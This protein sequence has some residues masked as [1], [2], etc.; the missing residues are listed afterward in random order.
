VY[1]VSCSVIARIPS[2]RVARDTSVLSLSLS[3]CIALYQ[4]SPSP[5]SPSLSN[6]SMFLLFLLSFPFSLLLP[7][8]STLSLSSRSPLFICHHLSLSLSPPPPI[9]LPPPLSHTICRSPATMAYQSSIHSI[10]R[11]SHH[12]APIMSGGWRMCVP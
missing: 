10:S 1:A 4:P 6:L 5:L 3:R 12:T 7:P 9:L 8:S 2:H 11:T